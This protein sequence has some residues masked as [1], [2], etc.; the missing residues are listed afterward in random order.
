MQYDT[1]VGRLLQDAIDAAFKRLGKVNILIAGKTGV[2][3]STLVN[4]IFQGNFADTAQG[5]PV[6]LATREY[7]KE[8]VPL[9]IFDTRGLEVASYQQTLRELQNLVESRNKEADAN[10][11]IHLA[12]LCITEDSRR[13]ETAETE[14]VDML[15]AYMPVLGVITKARA[16]D[17]FRATVIELLPK[18]R[19]VVRVRA[20][21][22][23][24]DDGHIRYP[25]G[26][27]KLVEATMEI[28][29]EGHR[30]ALA[31]AQQVSIQQKINRAHAVVSTAAAS[32]GAIGATPIP[33]ADAAALVP[34]QVA[35]LAGT[36]AVFGLPLTKAFLSTLIFSA[37]TGGGGTIGGRLL[38][39]ELFKLLPGAG[40][41]V[42][43]IITGSTAAILTALFG[44]AYIATLSGLL[45][46]NPE[47][48]L[49][50]EQIA[51]A[52]KRE[53]AMGK[54]A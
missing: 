2:G 19:N 28:I 24:D 26:L 32:A 45:K 37:I 13:V 1:N 7:T 18:V 17:N 3:K 39:G 11:H 5:R 25:M 42:G 47:K 9:T 35:M 27:D 51:Q 50:P 29:P 34:L 31:A 48:P 10:R 46:E 23:Q 43:G 16:D 41:I 4:A 54:L 21:L 8:G 6:T 44:E 40:S 33:F 15:A 53:L 22:E 52:F 14:L 12:W 38:V 49:T 30:S 36:S 20:K